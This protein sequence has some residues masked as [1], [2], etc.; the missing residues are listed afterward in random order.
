MKFTFTIEGRLES[1]NKTLKIPRYR[2]WQSLRRQKMKTMIERWICCSN[3][4]QFK[5]P[6]KIHI[7]WV[8]KNK[9]RDFDNIR[10]GA[11]LILDALTKSERIVNDSQ[12]WLVG[13]TDA[14]AIDPLRPRI[15]VTITEAALSNGP[16]R[17]G[18]SKCGS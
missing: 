14:Y 11:K 7:L 12:R 15:E 18:E 8:E 16:A 2:F 1:L 13:L 9:R 5:M 6:V 17:P 3:V 10:S 4:P